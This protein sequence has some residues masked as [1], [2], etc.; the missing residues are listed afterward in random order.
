M[1]PDTKHCT[2]GTRVC[3]CLS[4][5]LC[6]CV[7]VYVC[8]CMRV[9]VRA[10]YRRDLNTSLTTHTRNRKVIE[11]VVTIKNTESLANQQ[12]NKNSRKH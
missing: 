5:C 1:S 7:C 4:V 8:A 2:Q 11:Q 6:V 9:C 10:I 12:R 3:L